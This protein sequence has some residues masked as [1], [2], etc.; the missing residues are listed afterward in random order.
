MGARQE[1]LLAGHSSVRFP[2]PLDAMGKLSPCLF[3]VK[4]P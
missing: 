3:V 2:R 4:E 1:K